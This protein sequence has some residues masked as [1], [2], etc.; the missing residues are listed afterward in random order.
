MSVLIQNK[1][2][3]LKPLENERV[4]ASDETQLV[5]ATGFLKAVNDAIDDIKH[6][7]YL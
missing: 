3:E 1:Y 2:G 7:S 4:E 6:R 5:Y